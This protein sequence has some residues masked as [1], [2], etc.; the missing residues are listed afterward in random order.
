MSK[1]VLSIP[2][3]MSLCLSH[4][5]INPTQRAGT[6]GNEG[7]GSSRHNP[8]PHTDHGTQATPRHRSSRSPLL[9]LRSYAAHRLH[10]VRDLR[11][12]HH[13]LHRQSA[14]LP[15]DGTPGVV[16]RHHQLL[17]LVRNDMREDGGQNKGYAIW[18]LMTA[19]TQRYRR[20]CHR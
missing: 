10:L 11:R 19:I 8:H 14:L 1:L 18:H 3:L 2:V 20:C 12:P 13:H 16:L 7:P 6:V 17:L 5:A 4:T 9:R 15:G